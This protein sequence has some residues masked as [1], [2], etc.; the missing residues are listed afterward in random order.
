MKNAFAFGSSKGQMLPS[1]LPLPQKINRFHIPGV[2]CTC[3][4]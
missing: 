3:P 2:Q 1:L 4:S